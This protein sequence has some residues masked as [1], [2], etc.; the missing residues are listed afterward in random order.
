MTNPRVLVCIKLCSL[1]LLVMLVINLVG[2]FNAA[3]A[4]QNGTDCAP[5]IQNGD[6]RMVLHLDAVCD[7]NGNPTP[8]PYAGEGTHSGCYDALGANYG[9][10]VQCDPCP[11]N[12]QNCTPCPNYAPTCGDNTPDPQPTPPPGGGLYRAPTRLKNLA[13]AIWSTLDWLTA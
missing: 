5:S 7:G 2:V 1:M 4:Q 8:D 11:A 6:D 10:T 9:L 13:Q 3:V 12:W